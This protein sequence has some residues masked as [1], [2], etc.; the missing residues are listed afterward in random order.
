MES[1]AVTST[2]EAASNP[3]HLILTGTTDGSATTGS[4][5]LSPDQLS[6]EPDQ[7]AQQVEPLIILDLRRVF[8]QALVNKDFVG[9]RK[10]VD[11]AIK[12]LTLP[13]PE[14]RVRAQLLTHAERSLYAQAARDAE[15]GAPFVAPT[16]AAID[17]QVEAGVLVW[18]AKQPIV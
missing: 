6:V 15:K 11:K 18:R 2:P 4:E 14:D 13:N 16:K 5:H 9:D 8:A 17:A 1:S 3:S 7:A 12:A 10:R